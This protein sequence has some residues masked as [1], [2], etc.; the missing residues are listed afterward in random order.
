MLLSSGHRVN[1]LGVQV[2]LHLLRN[3]HEVWKCGSKK[4]KVIPKQALALQALE[5]ISNTRTSSKF[6]FVSRLQHAIELV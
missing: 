6:P 5:S 2:C 4:H 3:R 1:Y